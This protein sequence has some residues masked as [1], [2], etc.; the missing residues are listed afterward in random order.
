MNG[1]AC[2]GSELSEGPLT[3]TD[4]LGKTSCGRTTAQCQGTVI[5]MTYHQWVGG[6]DISW[7]WGNV[8]CKENMQK[9]SVPKINFFHGCSCVEPCLLGFAHME[10]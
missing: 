5:C 3:A 4:A 9:G 6:R 8:C 10:M 1:M 2:I 7:G